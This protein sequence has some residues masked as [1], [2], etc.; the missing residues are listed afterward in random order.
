MSDLISR[1]AAIDA[2]TKALEHMTEYENNEKILGAL[3]HAGEEIM[4]AI[5]DLPSAAHTRKIGHW[6][7]LNDKDEWFGSVYKCSVCG[8]KTLDH[9]GFCSKCGSRMEVEKNGKT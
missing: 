8:H 9:E 6:I 1:Q 7:D 4:Y 5:M 3:N 2:A